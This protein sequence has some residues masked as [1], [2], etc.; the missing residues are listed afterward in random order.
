MYDFPGPIPTTDDELA[1]WLERWLA[2]AS[3]REALIEGHNAPFDYLAHAFFEDRSPRDCVVWANRGGGK[4]FLGAVATAMDM[5][6]KPGI[7]I[8]VLAGSLEQARRM[9]AHLRDIFERDG[10]EGMVEGRITERRIRLT[11][12]SCVETLAQSQ[13][14]V[15]GT[16]V[17]KLRCDE[18]ELFDR[19][20][21]EAAQLVTRS[22]ECGPVRVRGAIECLS[23]MHIPYGIMHELVGAAIEGRARRLFRW[24]VVDTLGPCPD[25]D[26]QCLADEGPCPL[27][28]E[29]AGLAKAR[30]RRAMPPGHTAIPDAIGMKA[31]VSPEVWNAEMLCLRPRRSDCV[32]PEFDPRTHVV[33]R[34]PDVSAAWPVIAGMDFGIRSPTVVL[35]ARLSP[36]GV[37]YVVREHARAGLSLE[38]HAE[39]IR[40]APERFEWIGVD[41]AGRNRSIQTGASDVQRLRHHGFVVRDARRPL[42][43]GIELVRARLRTADGRPRLFIT[44]DCPTLIESLERYRYPPNPE[45]PNPEKDGHDHAPDALRY[46][47]QNLDEPYRTR[48]DNYTDR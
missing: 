15:R 41:P 27:A 1:A 14:S 34:P 17:Q 45:N 35:W 29:C 12:T 46:M 47:I 39:I 36:D 42:H 10:F 21:W 11:N 2:L 23:T 40:A 38:Q 6:F 28:A 19:A 13:T 48:R 22:K 25:D 9:Q 43:E 4:T 44:R 3:P 5:V 26:H 37:V 30:D 7:E 31:R 24:G 16:R 33:E 8:R 32:L 18:V 20:V